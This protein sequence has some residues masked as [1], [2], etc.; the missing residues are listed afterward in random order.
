MI[1]RF[2]DFEYG[3]TRYTPCEVDSPQALRA[4]KLKCL[5]L[6]WDWFAGGLPVV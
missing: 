1:E 4:I 6:V 3:K 5:V 2:A